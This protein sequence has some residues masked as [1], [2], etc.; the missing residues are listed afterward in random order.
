M[1]PPE[2][3][4]FAG[5]LIVVILNSPTAS[6][7]KPSVRKSAENSPALAMMEP[8]RWNSLLADWL[9]ATVVDKMR[10]L[11]SEALL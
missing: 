8:S 11:K 6:G 5:A 7:G 9:P 4:Y 2:R 10:E 1:P 3:P